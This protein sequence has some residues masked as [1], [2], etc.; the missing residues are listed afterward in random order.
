MFEVQC[1][2]RVYPLK[3][4]VGVDTLGGTQHIRSCSSCNLVLFLVRAY[5][6]AWPTAG[7]EVKGEGR[8]LEGARGRDDD[9]AEKC[10]TNGEER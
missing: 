6:C 9:W 3:E 2:P 4:G 5:S 7:P 8:E 10:G 1:R